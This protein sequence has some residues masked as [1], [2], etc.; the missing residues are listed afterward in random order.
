VAQVHGTAAEAGMATVV[1]H[2]RPAGAVDIKVEPPRRPDPQ[3]DI[4][5]ERGA[6]NR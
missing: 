6:P 2:Y 5:I 3:L 1:V 4:R